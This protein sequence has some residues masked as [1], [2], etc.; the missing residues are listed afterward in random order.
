M[1]IQ[2]TAL[3]LD[4]AQFGTQ[5]SRFYILPVA[6]RAQLATDA[7]GKLCQLAPPLHRRVRARHG[8]WLALAELRGRVPSEFRVLTVAVAYGSADA[9]DL[10]FKLVQHGFE[11]SSLV[12]LV[13]P[14]LVEL[15]RELVRPLLDRT[16]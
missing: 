4:G 14:Q 1:L 9:L 3:L 10:G 6:Q 12:I 15:A 5:P 2:L 16:L 13:M 11:F 7:S 8:V